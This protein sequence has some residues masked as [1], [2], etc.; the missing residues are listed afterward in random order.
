MMLMSGALLMALQVS[1]LAGSAFY[2]KS[3]EHALLYCATA[4]KKPPITTDIGPGDPSY[5]RRART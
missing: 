4:A 3:P 5:N 1:D 2:S